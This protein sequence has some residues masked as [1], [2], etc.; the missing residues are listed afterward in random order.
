MNSMAAPGL[1]IRTFLLAALSLSIGWGIR[2]NFGHEYGA[3]IPGALTAIAVC[4]LS[5][6]E[7]WQRRCVHFAMFGALGWGFGGSISYMQVISYTHS[8]HAPSQLYG[9]LALFLIGFLW[10]GLGGAGTAL[11]AVAD[12]K[13]L[14]ELFKPLIWILLLW[15]LLK[16]G[17]APIAGYYKQAI[18]GGGTVDQ[19]GLRHQ[20][21]F[22]WFDS[23]WLQAFFALVALCL[24]DLTDRIV[25]RRFKPLLE[26]PCLALLPVVGGLLGW[27]VQSTLHAS[28]ND[29]VVA[30]Y[31]IVYQGDTERFDPSALMTNWPQFFSDFVPYLGLAAGVVAGVVIYFAVFGQW[32]SGASLFL[33]MA[34]GWFIVFLLLPVLAPTAVRAAHGCM[35]YVFA[36]PVSPGAFALERWGGFRLTPPRSDDWA[37]VAGVFVGALIY[38]L[39][40]GLKPVAYTGLVSGFVGGLGFAGAACLKLL[41]V[42]P[43]NP[44][45]IPAA[46]D[47]P[48][49]A[50]WQSAN[51]HSFLEQ[52]YGFINGLG[53]ALAMGLLSVRV[54]FFEPETEQRSGQ[55]WTSVFAAAFVVLLIPYLNLYKN[56]TVWVNEA[57]V[58]PET[59]RAPLL[60]GIGDGLSFS[61][62]TWFNVTYACFALAVLTV[63]LTHVRRP[64]AFLPRSS[65]GLGQV[66]FLSLLWTM[67]VGNFERALV[68][69]T[70]Q[71]ILT[72]WIVVINSILASLLI[73][74]V[75][76]EEDM[77]VVSGE[78]RYTGRDFARMI[79]LGCVACLCIVLM[80][81]GAVRY[82]YGNTFAGHAGYQGKPQTRFGEQAE[83]R[84]RP[85]LKSETHR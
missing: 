77:V 15:T 80:Q 27:L 60:G 40:K 85:I 37:G 24:F 39:R 84:I 28:G 49:W 3:M 46:A 82:V 6:R 73:L 32:R 16:F 76:R 69:F 12:R 9:F 74:L 33:H 55:K 29:G 7:D 19:S 71:R 64:L 72:E 78:D 5:G 41:M 30:D 4:L 45:R 13:R 21:P 81:F 50:F 36:S 75:P 63:L 52:S 23:D 26:I 38:F 57:R 18:W 51:W 70:E 58:V 66:L 34:L 14:T 43:G 65:L 25:N 47:D 22:Y 1:R 17:E 20:N 8:G 56:V 62:S 2:G 61:A 54:P 48:F 67:V 42:A 44:N 10:A 53:I 79:A 11:P 83:W 59:M 35:A 31:L 68:G